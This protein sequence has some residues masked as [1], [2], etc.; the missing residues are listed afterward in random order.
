MLAPPDPWNGRLA[1]ATQGSDTTSFTYDAR[2]NRASSTVGSATTNYSWNRLGQLATLDGESFGYSANGIRMSVGTAQ[3]VYDQGLK[4]LSDGKMKYLWGPNGELLAQAPLG[5]TDS[6]QTQ[7]AVSDGMNSVYAVLDSQL[8]VLGEYS[9]TAFGERTLTA[10][11]DASS[12]GF[13]SEQHDASGLVYLRYRY[14]DPTVGQFISVDPMLGSTL[15]AYGYASGNPLQMTDPLTTKEGAQWKM[16][17]LSPR[18][19]A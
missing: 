11:T 7:Q 3:Q 1:T 2:G 10:G 15:D 13:T 19:V 16:Q 6:T 4:L 12:M 8:D 5:S 18:S 17:S 9:Y 14:M